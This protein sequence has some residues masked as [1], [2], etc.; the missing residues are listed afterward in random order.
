[1]FKQTCVHSSR[2]WQSTFSL[3]SVPIDQAPQP[4][5]NLNLELG[6]SNMPRQSPNQ[7]TASSSAGPRG[8]QTEDKAFTY[9]QPKK[10]KN[11]IVTLDCIFIVIIAVFNT[12]ILFWLS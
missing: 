3:G 4:G 6:G 10:A 11:L 8:E 5:L 1:M 12:S 9:N 2:P 7:Q